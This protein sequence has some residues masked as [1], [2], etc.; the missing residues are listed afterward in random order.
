M[1]FLGVCERLRS[2]QYTKDIQLGKDLHWKVTLK[3][4]SSIAINLDTQLEITGKGH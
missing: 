2:P 4:N 3:L 1:E